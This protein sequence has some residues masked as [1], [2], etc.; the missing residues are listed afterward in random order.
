MILNSTL[1]RAAAQQ[2]DDLDGQAR[3]LS[4]QKKDIF[5][6]I[7]ETIPPADFKAWKEAVK[8]RQKRVHKRGE[9]EAHDELVFEMLSMLEATTLQTAYESALAAQISPAN[10]L[11]SQEPRTRAGVTDDFD[12]ETGEILETPSRAMI[13]LIE[14]VTERDGAL[15]PVATAEAANKTLATQGGAALASV[16]PPEP[17][18]VSRH[19]EAAEP[20]GEIPESSVAEI[21]AGTIPEF[22]KKVA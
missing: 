16:S 2:I 21:D 8:L 1:L 6:N 20:V 9:I 13:G 3:E 18:P 5:D 14:P 15:T 12:A 11:Q 17:I 22:L 7:K 19:G 4:N 10:G